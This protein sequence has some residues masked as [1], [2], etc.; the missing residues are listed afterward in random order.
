M[1]SSGGKYLELG[2][3]DLL[4]VQNTPVHRLDP[5]AKVITVLVFTVL[6]VSFDR[7][8]VAA[9]LP[10][11]IFPVFLITVG[12]LPFRYLLRRLLVVVPFILVIGI[13]N[14]LIDRQALLQLGTFTITGGWL[15]FCSILLRSVLTVLTML[16]LVATT[17]F[18]GVCAALNML[19]MPRVFSL[20]LLF[21]YRYLFVLADEGGR[22]SRARDLR[23]FGNRGKDIGTYVSLVGHLM[24]RTFDRAQKIYAAML[25]RGFSG[26]FHLR[27]SI[28]F[29]SREVIFIAGWSL[30]FLLFR[31]VD[32]PVLLGGIITG[33]G[34]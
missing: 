33:G 30:L 4:S 19:G 34:R 21:M 31:F 7:Y 12:N 32:I 29:G 22:M 17:G 26:H 5:R 28:G 23:T 10:F 6:V 15:S 8:R 18:I 24:L 20:Q 11:V 13:F 1:S 16:A 14:P 9:L 2:Y 3:L 27:R 25:A